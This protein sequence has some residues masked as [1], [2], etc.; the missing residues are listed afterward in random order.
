MLLACYINQRFAGVDL[1]D[2]SADFLR[3]LQ[4]M[5]ILNISQTNAF[6]F[7][8]LSSMRHLRELNLSQTL[9]KDDSAPVVNPPP[10]PCKAEPK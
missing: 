9:V 4:D 8:F 7:G 3:P 6:G 10:S 2:G 1:S 5:R